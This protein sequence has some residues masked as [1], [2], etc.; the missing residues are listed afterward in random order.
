MAVFV[1]NFSWVCLQHLCNLKLVFCGLLAP[2]MGDSLHPFFSF[3]LGQI[4]RQAAS[5]SGSVV[6]ACSSQ[7]LE[8]KEGCWR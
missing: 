1:S 5:K 6:G 2:G 7:R 8:V 3:S 4:H